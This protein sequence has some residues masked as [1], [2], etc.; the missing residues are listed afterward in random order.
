MTLSVLMMPF[1]RSRA[2]RYDERVVGSLR[3][4]PEVRGAAAPYTFDRFVDSALVD[5]QAAVDPIDLSAVR[6]RVLD[7]SGDP[8]ARQRMIFLLEV[9]PVY[10]VGMR[11]L[12]GERQCH[13]AFV[14]EHRDVVAALGSD[15]DQA[16]CRGG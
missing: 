13:R 10:G 5:A 16:H 9:A 12:L 15:R 11:L 6:R 8:F 4:L 2:R 1:L 7:Q 14:S 3:R